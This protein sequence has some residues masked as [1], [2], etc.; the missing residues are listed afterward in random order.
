MTGIRSLLLFISSFVLFLLRVAN[1]HVGTTTSK[2]P[3]QSTL[4]EA[5]SYSPVGTISCYTFSAWFFSEVYLS[6]LPSKAKLGLVDD[7]GVSGRSHLN[8][9]AVFFRAQL[10]WL[11]CIQT[12]FHLAGDY[13]RLDL[14]LRKPMS[15]AATIGPKAQLYRKLQGLL[16]S[17]V[18]KSLVT[19]G[20][21]TFLYF[22]LFRHIAW[23]C[24]FAL[25]KYFYFWTRNSG[26][27]GNIPSGI[28]DLLF[29]TFLAQFALLLLWEWTNTT[30]SAY[31]AEPPLKK[32]HP[33]TDD[34]KDPNGSLLSGLRAK[35]QFAKVWTN[36]SMLHIDSSN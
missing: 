29:K 21:G 25:T 6:S 24:S 17:T 32:G 31:I 12:L 13:N 22:G 19:L 7:G 20:S 23:N 2:S 14:P 1:K 36:Y 35:K 8:E 28:L 33:L 30:L 34:S 3:I 27:K 11:P 9:R 16:V 4:W 15:Q 5:F 18:F 26:P 10:L